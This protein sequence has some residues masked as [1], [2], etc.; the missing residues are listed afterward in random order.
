LLYNDTGTVGWGDGTDEDGGVSFDGLHGGDYVLYVRGGEGGFL[1][2]YVEQD[3][4]RRV[5]S[6]E[7][8][9]EQ[10]PVEVE[11]EQG[12]RISGTLSSD[13]GWPV[14]GATLRL[15][16]VDGELSEAGSSDTEG[17][18]GLNGLTRGEW[19]LEA[20]FTPVCDG[21]AGFVTVYW[22]GVV[23]PDLAEPLDLV[24]GEDWTELTMEL[25]V[26]A[27]RDGMS[28]AWEEQVGLDPQADDAGEDPDGDGSSNVEEY[29]AGTDPMEREVCGCRAGH[30]AWVWLPFAGWRAR[31]RVSLGERGT[32]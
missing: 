4:E 16:S 18:F 31:R 8:G 5:F 13:E 21:D 32:G 23:N 3:G 15:T 6:V 12:S 24:P 9:I 1:D 22:P 2:G 26:D 27:D 7:A 30:T 20:G 25:P 11:L 14:G 28:D 17:E 29:L 19:I 10:G